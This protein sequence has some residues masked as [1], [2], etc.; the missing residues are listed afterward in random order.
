MNSF[1]EIYREP[2]PIVVIGDF[3]R[4][5]GIRF[6]R[7]LCQLEER[8]IRAILPDNVPFFDEYRRMTLRL[9]GDLP[10]LKKAALS[11]FRSTG[12]SLTPQVLV[13]FERGLIPDDVAKQCAVLALEA[14]S[15]PVSRGCREALVM[16][17][18]NTL[19]PV[20]ATIRATLASDQ[21]LSETEVTC[22]TV[23]DA[24]LRKVSADG[25]CDLL[26]LGTMGIEHVYQKAVRGSG[27]P[28]RIVPMQ[29][30][31]QS[32][33]LAAIH[34]GLQ[35][36]P[37]QRD[38]GANLLSTVIAEARSRHGDSLRI[39]EACTD[40]DFGLGLSSTLAYAERAVDL[41]Y[42]D[43]GELS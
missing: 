4:A 7:L 30:H 39:V 2:V 25:P 6:C 11:A 28:V 38:K 10:F 36:D 17:P 5:A 43:K 42:S 21:A 26:V 22:P 14:L 1:Q 37:T 20:Q 32:M 29:P 40:L 24:V 18:C 34:S 15:G 23:A 35:D 31:W 16:V 13:G 27:R 3:G 19:S 41:V 9:V 8:R 12:T 33:V